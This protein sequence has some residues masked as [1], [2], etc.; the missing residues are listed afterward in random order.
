[1]S[2]IY[3]YDISSLRVNENMKVYIR[4]LLV[5]E[6]QPLESCVHFIFQ[7]FG[8]GCLRNQSSLRIHP[9]WRHCYV[10]TQGSAGMSTLR[11]LLVQVETPTQIEIPT[12]AT[13]MIQRNKT[14]VRGKSEWYVKELGGARLRH[15]ATNRQVASSIPDGVIGIF[16]W[17]NSSGRTMALGSTQPLTEMS[18]RCISWG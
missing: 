6:S 1:M 3:I 17:H 14:T 9:D 11:C 18:T 15:Y 13:V 8:T 4:K 16:Q 10:I 7:K 2:S 5:L 12:R